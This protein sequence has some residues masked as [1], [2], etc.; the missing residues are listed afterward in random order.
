MEQ[1]IKS[2]ETGSAFTEADLFDDI[3]SALRSDMKSGKI[4]T[5]QF[6]AFK[7]ERCCERMAQQF[8]KKYEVIES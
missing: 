1:N 8:F 5:Y 6:S 2:F 4:E 7:E 3:V